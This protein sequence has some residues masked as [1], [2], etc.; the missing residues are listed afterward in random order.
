MQDGPDIARIASLLGD[1]ARAEVLTALLAD[2]AL[3]ATELSAIAGVTKQTMSAHLS[4][5]LEARLVAV[6]A[7]GRHRYFRLAD[8]D[9]AAVLRSIEGVA[10]RTGAL[11]PRAP[12]RQSALRKARICYDH[13]AG[14]IAVMAFEQLLQARV[15][16][17]VG[18]ELRLTAGGARWFANAG[19]DAAALGARRRR[20][21]R[22][23]RDWC[24]QR[25][26]LAGALGRALLLRVCD[27]GWASRERA[28][29]VV[30][31]TAR[32]EQCF[33]ELLTS[34]RSASAAP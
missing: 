29:R 2:R 23:C 3:T 31:F 8:A 18:A 26:H 5:L 4:K 32:G 33:R 9:V 22:P 21:L 30:R 1:Q 7:R 6:D 24:E 25:Q 11:C 12:P 28:S 16:A 20:L 19:I 27:L 10:L 14:D 17:R 15:L 13:L 34:A